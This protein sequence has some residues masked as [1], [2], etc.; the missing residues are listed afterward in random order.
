MLTLAFNT[1]S[2]LI[3]IALFAD[4]KLIDFHESKESGKQ[5]ELLLVKLMKF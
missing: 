5:S 2:S 3:S 4:G 1:S